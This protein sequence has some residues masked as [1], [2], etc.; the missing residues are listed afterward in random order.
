MMANMCMHTNAV[1]YLQNAMTSSEAVSINLSSRL[2]SQEK[3]DG[4]R[5]TPSVFSSRFSV[6]NKK[7]IYAP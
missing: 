7:L 5:S 6:K 1:R 4:V 3:T 2:P